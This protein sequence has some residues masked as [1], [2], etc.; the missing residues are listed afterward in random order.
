MLIDSKQVIENQGYSKGRVRAGNDKTDLVFW[1]FH[2][3]LR[4]LG[5][6]HLQIR[7]MHRQSMSSD[8]SLLKKV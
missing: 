7:E 3:Q 8:Y 6:F 4:G 1:A 5:H 2:Y